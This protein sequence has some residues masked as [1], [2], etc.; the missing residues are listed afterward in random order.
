MPGGRDEKW[1]ETGPRPSH[2]VDEQQGSLSFVIL[3]NVGLLCFLV[4]SYISNYYVPG[5]CLSPKTEVN[6]DLCFVFEILV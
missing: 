1:R 4:N 3:A 6:N 2:T 5:P